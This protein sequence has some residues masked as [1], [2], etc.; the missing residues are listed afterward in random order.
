[1]YSTTQKACIQTV[2]KERDTFHILPLKL[3]K[4]WEDF[5][6]TLFVAYIQ[7]CPYAVQKQNGQTVEMMCPSYT[8]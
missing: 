5:Q 1:M 6:T 2:D 3:D 4:T 7:N 8:W